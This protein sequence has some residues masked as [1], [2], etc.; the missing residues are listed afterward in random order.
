[1]R[2]P[3]VIRSIT[4]QPDGLAIE[5]ADVTKDLHANGLQLSHVVFIPAGDDYDDE[6]DA[7]TMAAQDA[8]RDALQDHDNLPPMDPALVL[9]SE[10]LAAAE[11]AGEDDE[12]EGNT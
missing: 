1:V 6:I 12:D 9:E 5:Y 7:V 11:A 3:Y 4:V 10:A 8:L 2:S